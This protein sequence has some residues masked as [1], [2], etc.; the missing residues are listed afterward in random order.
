MERDVKNMDIERNDLTFLAV[1]QASYTGKNTN[2]CAMQRDQSPRH[3]EQIDKWITIFHHRGVC[4]LRLRLRHHR[5]EDPD[6][7]RY[8]R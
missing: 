1:N 7:R 8:D 5:S 4:I 3:R 2:A 6:H